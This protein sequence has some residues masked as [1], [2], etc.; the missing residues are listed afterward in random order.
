M[1]EGCTVDDILCT[2]VCI[3]HMCSLYWYTHTHT[4]VVSG[5]KAR[6]FYAA[7]NIVMFVTGML[8]IMLDP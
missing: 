7:K 5:E 1:L 6:P 3:N 2:F 8:A 4:S